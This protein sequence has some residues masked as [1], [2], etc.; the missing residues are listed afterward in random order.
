MRTRI[1]AIAASAV[2]VAGL[3]GMALAPRLA[4]QAD[5]FAPCREGQVAG[6]DIG[7]PFTLVNA[8]GETVTDQDTFTKP[9]ILYFGFAS[10]PDVCPLDVARNA[11]AADILKEQ[12]IEASPVFVSVDPDRDTPEV[13]GRYVENFGE[14]VIGLTGSPEQVDAA[15]KAYR[16]YYAKQDGDPEYYLVDHSTFSYLVL[17]E[18]GFV[19]FVDRDETPEAVADRLACFARVAEA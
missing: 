4:G 5:A 13:V 14:G 18:V 16:V 15:A 17:P 2:A 19:D 12:G 1:V 8:A 3:A 6:G 11:Q 9:S 10:C 7:G